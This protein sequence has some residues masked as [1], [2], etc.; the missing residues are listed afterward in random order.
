MKTESMID[1]KLNGT[2]YNNFLQQKQ[3]F[4]DL[5]RKRIFDLYIKE[6][7]EN[8][9]ELQK[10]QETPEQVRRKM[11]ERLNILKEEREK[12]RI[13][14]VKFNLHR[15]FYQS[16]DELRKND[17]D[18]F[19]LSCYLEQ[20]NQMLDKLK[21]RQKEKREEEIYNKLQELD[22]KKKCNIFLFNKIKK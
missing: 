21:N 7:Y 3:R 19:A 11:E 18:A 14:L 16:A 10:N 1:N 5:R 12:E 8:K 20:E 9:I 2:R 13:E 15:K 4:L 6:D 17:S 22:S